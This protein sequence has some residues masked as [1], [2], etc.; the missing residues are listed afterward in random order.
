MSSVCYC[1]PLMLLSIS[2]LLRTWDSGLEDAD[3]VSRLEE[4]EL[5]L[6]ARVPI[7]SMEKEHRV[8]NL[9]CLFCEGL[10]LTKA[11]INYIKPRRSSSSEALRRT[12][13]VA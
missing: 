9:S 1:M 12:T 2:E 6:G 11:L 10:L 3:K 5:V 4:A 8:K 13:S 7:C